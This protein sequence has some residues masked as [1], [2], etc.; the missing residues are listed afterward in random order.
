MVLCN[1]I[2]IFQTPIEHVENL[3]SKIYPKI[4]NQTNS[5]NHYENVSENIDIISIIP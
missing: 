1:R 3:M 2:K 4:V 5:N